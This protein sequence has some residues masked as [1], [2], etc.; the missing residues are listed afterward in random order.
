MNLLS[1][2]DFGRELLRTNDLDPVY[3]VA[4]HAEFI[5][6]DEDEPDFHKWLLAYWCFYHVGTASWIVDQPDYWKAMETA[7]GSNDWP[8]SSERRHFRGE[9][10]AKSVRYLKGRGVYDLFTEL[11]AVGKTAE[12]VCRTVQRWVGFGP[13]IAFKVADMLERLDV[14]PVVFDLKTVLY[15]SPLKASQTLWEM[16]GRPIEATFGPGKWAIERV[17]KEVGPVKAPPRY[18]RLINAQEAETILCKWGSYRNGHYHVGE[19]VAAVRKGLLRFARC[20]TS[21]RLLKAGKRGELW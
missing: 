17:L 20:E 10:A 9:N 6:N 12:D 18:E 7:A 2:Y 8:R 15:D 16:E 19:D 5:G 1:C 3:V 14:R 13:W 11:L 4:H 21:Q